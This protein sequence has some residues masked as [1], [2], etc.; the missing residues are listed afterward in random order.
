MEASCSKTSHEGNKKGNWKSNYRPVSHLQF[1]SKVVKKCTLDQLTNH[2]NEYELLPEYQSAYGKNY[3]CETSFLR[4]VNDT[5]WAMDNKLITAVTVMDLSVAFDTVSHDLLL[6]VL[7]EQIGIKDVA[8]NWYENYLKP[9]YFKFALMELSHHKKQWISVYHKA[10]PKEHIYLFVICIN[11]QWKCAKII[12]FKWLCL[13][14]FKQ[15]V[16]QTSTTKRK[17]YLNTYQWRWHHIIVQKSVL[18]INSW[19][20][21]VKLKLNESQI[22]FIYFDR[23][24]QLAKTNRDTININIETIKCTNKIKYLQCHLDSLLTFKD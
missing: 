8:L 13:W 3:S 24:Q 10:Q 2:C 7:R 14:S 17:W 22:E 16:I 11:I 5:L 6:A 18:D 20:D 19:M 21:A 12:N 4:L 23:R 15:K 9:R 1:I